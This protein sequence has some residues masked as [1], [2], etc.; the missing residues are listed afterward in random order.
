M[1]LLPSPEQ[2]QV[3]DAIRG[4]LA[5]EAPVERLRKHGATGNPD[6]RLWR[7]LGDLG[8]VGIAPTILLAKIAS[9]MQTGQAANK[10][11]LSREEVFRKR[12]QL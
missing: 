9:N 5:T 2:I 10:S 6:A 11:S 12:R 4:F 8:Y 3:L 7:A 1:D